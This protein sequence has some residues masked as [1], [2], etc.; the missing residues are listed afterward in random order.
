MNWEP[1]ITL[2]TNINPFSTKNYEINHKIIELLNLLPALVS[3]RLSH[4][5]VHLLP[6]YPFNKLP[7]AGIVLKTHFWYSNHP[8][9]IQK[10][11]ASYI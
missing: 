11:I 2:F 9:S 7:V 8:C 3:F 1:C 4:E 5:T 10:H 6:N